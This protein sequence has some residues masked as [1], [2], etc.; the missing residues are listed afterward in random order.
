M[1]HPFYRVLTPT[2][3]AT[4]PKS[5]AA[6]VEEVSDEEEPTTSAKKK[7]KKPKKKKKKAAPSEATLVPE[8]ALEQT[9]APAPEPAPAPAPEPA[10]ATPAAAQK[11]A[12]AK[13]P[14]AKA[15]SVKSVSASVAYASSTTSLPLPTE[16]TAQSARTYL[17][18]EGL[19]AEKTKVKTRADHGNLFS[20]PEKKK[21]L[22][23]RFTRE[24]AEKPEVD[25]EA[26]FS[27]FS[28]LSKRAKTYMHQLLS[29]TED[30]KRGL[31]PMKWDHFVKVRTISLAYR[32][33]VNVAVQV[34]TEMGFTY[35]PSTA[36]SSVRFDPPDPKDPVSNLHVLCD[37]SDH[38]SR[39]ACHLPQA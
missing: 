38:I 10:P 27:M 22:F 37:V 3:S 19:D 34:M 23:S 2:P 18:S 21:G 11:K 12:P 39:S 5:Q 13:Q 8:E 29:T 26:K 14:P 16:Q 32:S 33:F 1:L 17:K 25:Q 4:Q 6:T 20:I 15:P 24:K 35:V 7:K 9:P 36:G 28:N 30:E 31:A